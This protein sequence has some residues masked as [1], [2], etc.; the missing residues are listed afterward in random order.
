MGDSTLLLGSP[1]FTPLSEDSD[2]W[3]GS[4]SRS[5]HMKPPSHTTALPLLQ[6]PESA[7][8][9]QSGQAMSEQPTKQATAQAGYV[10]PGVVAAASGNPLQNAAIAS[11]AASGGIPMYAR[12]GFS[13]SGS[14]GG[15]APS[16]ALPTHP[17]AI[18]ADQS[19]PFLCK[20]QYFLV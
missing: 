14:S 12:H 3:F 7:S 8:R 5:S 10:V 17:Q 20:A 13:P 6:Q 2:H 15:I 18:A 19:A 9:I 11:C 1:D 4:N 16:F